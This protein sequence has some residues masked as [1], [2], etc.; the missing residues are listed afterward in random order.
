[1][2]QYSTEK[3]YLTPKQVKA[4]DTKKYTNLKMSDLNTLGVA[5]DA[6]VSLQTVPSITSPVQFFQYW[7]S[8]AVEVA[9]A[10]RTIDKIAGR[11]IAGA[12]EDE[13]IVVP[14][15][16]LTGS[17]RPYTDTANIPL[18]SYNPNFLARTIIRM[19]EGLEVGYLESLRASRMQRD[20]HELKARAVAESLAISAN[21]IGFF[22]FANGQNQTFGFLNDPNLPAYRTVAQNAGQNSTSW[23]NKT[24]NE[25]TADIITAVSQ[26]TVQLGGRFNPA[27]DAFKLVLSLASYQFLNTLNELGT[28]SVLE[29]LT[30]TYKVE[31]I[32]APELDGA[33]GGQNVFYLMLDEFNGSRVIDQYVPEV[34]RLIGMEKKA[35]VTVESYANATAG[36]IVQQP[37]GVVRYSGI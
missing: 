25:I 8:K 23:A 15:I 3:L 26:L 10:S 2:K 11:T 4:F 30:K 5:M 17:A 29:W 32:P 13:E 16:E 36:I 7:V 14:Y 21:D 35:K 37:V 6:Q 33:N 20:D 28:Q 18:A 12:F 9:T 27:V 1:M 22:G 34:L 31:I 19:E 24:F